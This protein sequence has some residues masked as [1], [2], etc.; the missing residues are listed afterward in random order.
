[1]KE[2]ISHE[3]EELRKEFEE[4]LQVRV[5]LTKLH[6]AEEMS[7]FFSNFMTKTVI[8][9][10]FFFVFMFFSL[11]AA[12]LLGQWL[13]SYTLGF[14]SIGMAFL[15]AAIIFWTLRK[16]IIERPVV[17]NFIKLLFPK[18]EDDEE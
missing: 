15:L 12:F 3:I 5:D 1:M 16:R 14:A 2:N 4:Y 13:E 8:L 6:I 7:R 9:Y 11:A 17:Q 18:F 10:L